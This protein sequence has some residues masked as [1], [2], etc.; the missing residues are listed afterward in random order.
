VFS[1]LR[2]LEIEGCGQITVASFVVL[3]TAC[4]NLELDVGGFLGGH[5]RFVEALAYHQ[6]KLTAFQQAGECERASER[7]RER[8][9]EREREREREGG[10]GSEITQQTGEN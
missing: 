10:G 2:Q 1:E 4:A 9:R 3:Q 7:E 6:E 5:G 8:A